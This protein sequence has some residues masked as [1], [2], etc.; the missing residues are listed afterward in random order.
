MPNRNGSSEGYRYG[1]N[2]Q[3]HEDEI[4]NSP[5]SMYSAEYWMYDSRLGRRWNVDPIYKI[6]ESSYST[7]ANNPIL[8]IDING[9]DT[10]NVTSKSIDANGNVYYFDFGP[11][12]KIKNSKADL[13]NPLILFTV[14]TKDNFKGNLNT[15]D[16]FTKY[17]TLGENISLTKDGKTES[18]PFAKF[19]SA[20]TA[21]IYFCKAINYTTTGLLEQLID[22]AVAEVGDYFNELDKATKFA[23][24]QIYDYKSK[25]WGADGKQLTYIEGFG[26][27]LSDQIGNF[28][29]G[30]VISQYGDDRII[31]ATYD[32]DWLQKIW[33]KN[34][35]YD[36]VYDSYALALGVLSSGDVS[37]SV[38]HN[39]LSFNKN[40]ELFTHHSDEISFKIKYKSGKKV[41]QYKGSYSIGSSNGEDYKFDL[42]KK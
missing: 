19:L 5:G 22:R 15:Q 4:T 17:Q 30:A 41:T 26:V 25:A 9:A 1:M 24:G 7:F 14:F 36:D 2:G 32:A 33:N 28:I 20:N 27:Y 23:H 42:F 34:K 8:N 40:I 10:I 35:Y 39:I 6:H 11:G 12:G 18:K 21:S 29:Y 16:F 38:F 31:D 3:E 13:N 37:K